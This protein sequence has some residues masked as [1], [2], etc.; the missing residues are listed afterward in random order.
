MTQNLIILTLILSQ[1]VFVYQYLKV[2]C[3]MPFILRSNVD[4]GQLAEQNKMSSLRCTNWVFIIATFMAVGVNQ[5]WPHVHELR[6]LVV[7]P[8][9]VLVGFLI[10]SVCKIKK[11]I[12]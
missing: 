11:L 9:L 6:L 5:V 4:E 8:Y 1:W 3:L 7:I 2:A 12:G 10:Y